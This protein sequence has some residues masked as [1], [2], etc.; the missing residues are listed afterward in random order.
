MA[1]SEINGSRV[2]NL[3]VEVR[4]P[5]E[6]SPRYRKETHGRGEDID[7]NTP[8][9]EFRGP[10]IFDR[11]KEEFEALVDT[12]Y[13]KKDFDHFVSPPKKEGGFRASIGRKLENISSPRSR[14][15]HQD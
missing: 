13:P 14:H 5:K 15:N 6:S 7:V 9:S 3:K 1:E 4:T 2:N 8:I 12:M 10:S 11:A